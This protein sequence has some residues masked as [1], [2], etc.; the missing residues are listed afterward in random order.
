MKQNSAPQKEKRKYMLTSGG[1]KARA[2]NAP[3]LPRN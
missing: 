1:S 3:S 2:E